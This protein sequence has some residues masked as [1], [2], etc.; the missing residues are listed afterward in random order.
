MKVLDNATQCAHK[1]KR[2]GKRILLGEPEQLQ[3]KRPSS[4]RFEDPHLDSSPG[5]LSKDSKLASA[6][7]SYRQKQIRLALKQDDETYDS[8]SSNLSEP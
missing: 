3:D 8:S 4:L 7:E 5:R 2:P 6:E 1:R